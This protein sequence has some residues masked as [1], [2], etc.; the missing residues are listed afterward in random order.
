MLMEALVV[1]A[2]LQQKGGCSES[3][4]AYY[5]SN[6]EIQ[7][8]VHNVD[9]FGKRIVR[10]NEWI[11]YAATPMYAIATGATANFHIHKGWM[12]GIDIKGEKVLLQWS[13]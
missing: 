1:T 8:I 3:T 7:D 6:K 2:C 13:Y 11:V 12:L 5:K 9:A 4:S 10:G